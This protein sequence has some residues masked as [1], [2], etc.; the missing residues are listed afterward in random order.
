MTNRAS[1]GK[2]HHAIKFGKASISIRAMASMANCE[3]HNQMLCFRPPV[4]VVLCDRGGSPFDRPGTR[5]WMT[6]M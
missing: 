1:H 5:L 4:M 2:I 3:C 6:G